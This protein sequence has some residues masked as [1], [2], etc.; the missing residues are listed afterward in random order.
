MS[1]RVAWDVESIAGSFSILSKYLSR[2]A[3]LASSLK[4]V[5]SRLLKVREGFLHLGKRATKGK[6]LRM[7]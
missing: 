6:I 7:P 5:V 2:L 4:Q 1:F 3:E